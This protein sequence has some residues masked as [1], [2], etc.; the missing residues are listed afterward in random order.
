MGRLAAAFAFL[1]VVAASAVPARA[2]SSPSWWN[3]DCDATHWNRAAAAQGWHGS[4]AHRLG[5][6][7]L[8]V[9]VCGP[10]PSGDHAPDVQWS[11]SGWGE[12][13]WECVELA[14]RF[15]ALVYGTSAY[16]ANGNNVVR[17]YSTSAGGG[18]VRIKNGTSGK[19][20]LPGDVIS[21]DNSSR[22]AGHV[23]VV[24]SS[25]VDNG[26]NGSIKA[27]SQNDTTNGWR[28]LA[29]NKWRVAAFGSYVPY[30]WLHD[31]KGR[32][33]GGATNHA[34]RGKVEQA[35]G[36]SGHQLRLRGWTVDADT[37][38]TS[39]KVII[40]IGGKRPKPFTTHVRTTADDARP[41]LAADHPA[42]GK[43]HGFDVT[44]KLPAAQMVHVDVYA[45]DTT[46]NTRRRIASFDVRVP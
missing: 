28:T 26:G 31:P 14:M 20:P 25:S 17:N 10:R 29:V 2:A 11:R 40:A 30:A 22:P 42:W 24:A 1:F 6:A 39:T 45:R 32:G 9:P 5:A 41:D 36:L 15:M 33:G 16:N 19:T 27:M 46:D 8:G 35:K 18:L 21:F 7:Y 23:L 13:E 43:Y 12:Y 3:G 44:T 38:T 34:P 4:G 37:P